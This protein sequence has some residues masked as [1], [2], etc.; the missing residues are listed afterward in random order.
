M[1][2]VALHSLFLGHVG[3]DHRPKLEGLHAWLGMVGI[4]SDWESEID[5]IGSSYLNRHIKEVA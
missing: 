5:D 2:S 4:R 3:L 1:I